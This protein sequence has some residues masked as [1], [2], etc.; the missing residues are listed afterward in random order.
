[1]LLRLERFH[2][3]TKLLLGRE[4]DEPDNWLKLGLRYRTLFWINHPRKPG[5][6][7]LHL[8]PESQRTR[9]STGE[10]RYP[11]KI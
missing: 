1:M 11:M 5:P 4:C 7:H 8:V 10:K 6:S 9:V 2:L 3:R